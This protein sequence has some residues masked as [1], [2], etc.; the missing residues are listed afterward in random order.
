MEFADFSNVF[1]VVAVGDMSVWVGVTHP[2]PPSYTRTGTESASLLRRF[3]VE[4]TQTSSGGFQK[5]VPH[6]NFG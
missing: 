2:Q 1:A 6:L 4:A 3:V 5:H